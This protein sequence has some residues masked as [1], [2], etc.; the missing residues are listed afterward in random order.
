MGVYMAKVIV[1]IPDDVPMSS[2]ASEAVMQTTRVVHGM[3]KW[4]G[5][6][7]H[8][9]VTLEKNPEKE[10]DRRVVSFRFEGD[11]ADKAAENVE[12]FVSN[13]FDIKHTYIAASHVEKG[14]GS[15][16][17]K[18]DLD[19]LSELQP[20]SFDSAA[21]DAAHNGS[22]VASHLARQAQGGRVV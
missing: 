12:F 8:V 18:M 3:A 16:T 1:D 6:D 17:I 11:K 7:V 10:G 15:A 20:K 4:F 21:Y 5:V 19:K 9:G 14:A 13:N 22:I 2:R